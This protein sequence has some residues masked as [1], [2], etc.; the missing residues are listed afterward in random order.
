MRGAAPSA[1]L[2]SHLPRNCRG[3]LGLS[4]GSGARSNSPPLPADLRGE[5]PGEGPLAGAAEPAGAHGLAVIPSPRVCGGGWRGTSRVGAF[6]RSGIPAAAHPSSPL[7]PRAE[8]RGEGAPG[9]LTGRIQLIRFNGERGETM[10]FDRIEDA[11]AGHPRRKDGHRR[12]RRG[13]RERGRP[14]V[15]RVGRHA[16][17][18]QLHGH[19]TGAASSAWRSPR[20]ART[21]WT[22]AP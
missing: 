22:C 15:R 21:S 17:D 13:P 9:I 20:S 10:P 5:G 1:R 11:I 2:G 19:G 6:G 3:R 7:S 16:R 4:R 8:G 18:H 12:R 14:G